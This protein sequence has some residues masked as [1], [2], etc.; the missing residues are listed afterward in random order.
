[1]SGASRGEP[2]ACLFRRKTGA[3]VGEVLGTPGKGQME[4]GTPLKEDTLEKKNLA[5]YPFRILRAQTSTRLAKASTRTSRK[6]EGRI[7]IKSQGWEGV[8]LGKRK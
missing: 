3:G 6:E 4:G 2:I 5:K 1:V 8:E 7:G